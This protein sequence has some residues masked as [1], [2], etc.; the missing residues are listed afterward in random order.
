MFMR[1][2]LDRGGGTLTDVAGRLK[3]SWSASGPRHPAMVV[4]SSALTVVTADVADAL[5]IAWDALRSAA[6]D[7]PTG[8]EVAA[9]AAQVLP[10]PQ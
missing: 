4:A 7:D 3:T 2:R 9:A 10:G 6:L 1:P 5:T 8:W